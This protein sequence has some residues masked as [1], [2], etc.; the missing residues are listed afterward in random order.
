MALLIFQV[1]LWAFEIW[2]ISSLFSGH[3]FFVQL[4]K[5]KERLWKC[6]FEVLLKRVC[7][8]VD[9]RKMGIGFQ[10]WSHWKDTLSNKMSQAYLHLHPIY[11]LLHSF[12]CCSLEQEKEWWI[13]NAENWQFPALLEDR[14]W[15]AERVP[16]NY[17]ISSVTML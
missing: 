8:V 16:G 17:Q 14:N 6:R 4:K 9:R 15:G 13:V 7:F 11:V 12:W 1:E 5:K 2:D 10:A 3:L